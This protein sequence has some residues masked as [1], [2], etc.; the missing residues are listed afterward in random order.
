MAALSFNSSEL[1]VDLRQASM[2]TKNGKKTRWGFFPNTAA[3]AA[4]RNKDGHESKAGVGR[5][6]EDHG[7]ASKHTAAEAPGNNREQACPATDTDDDMD[8]VMLDDPPAASQH[9]GATHICDISN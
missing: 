7:A 5:R 9:T 2:S 4:D 1:C 8:T 3:K 6:H